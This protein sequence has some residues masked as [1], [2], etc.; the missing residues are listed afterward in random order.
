M[1]NRQY[2]KVFTESGTLVEVER[3]FAFIHSTGGNSYRKSQSKK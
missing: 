2:N 1:Y 3:I